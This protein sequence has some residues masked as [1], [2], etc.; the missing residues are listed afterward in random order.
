[1]LQCFYSLYYVL[2]GAINMKPDVVALLKKQRIT[3]ACVVSAEQLNQLEQIYKS[4][5][6][7]AIPYRPKNFRQDS[8]CPDAYKGVNLKYNFV[9][10]QTQNACSSQYSGPTAQSE[11]ETKALLGLIEDSTQQV[12]SVVLL[13][14]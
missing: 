2:H 5:S 6:D 10:D 8:G 1:M 4:S 14:K 12:T 11:P 13:G 7:G 9:P 3:F